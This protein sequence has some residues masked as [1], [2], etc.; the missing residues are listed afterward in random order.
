[1][2]HPR[3]SFPILDPGCRHVRSRDGLDPPHLRRPPRRPL[4]SGHSAESL[5]HQAQEDALSACV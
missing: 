4:R 3:A 2:E 1:M 5:R